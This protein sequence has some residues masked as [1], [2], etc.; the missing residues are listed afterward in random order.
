[1][2]K[3]QEVYGLPHVSWHEPGSKKAR[4]ESISLL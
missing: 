1:M 2:G 3:D 4:V